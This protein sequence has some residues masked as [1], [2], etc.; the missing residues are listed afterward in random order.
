MLPSKAK[1]VKFPVFRFPLSVRLITN[2]MI[3][4]VCGRPGQ[5]WRLGFPLRRLAARGRLGQAGIGLY[6]F[7]LVGGEPSQGWR[8]GIPLRR[9]AAPDRLG[10]ADIGLYS[11]GLVCGEP[12]QGWR[13]GATN[14]RRG[15]W[16]SAHR[17]VRALRDSESAG[18]SQPCEGDPLAKAEC[19]GSPRTG[20]HRPPRQWMRMRQAFARLASRRDQPSQGIVDISPSVCEGA[21]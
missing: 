2:T 15:Q 6:S 12:A 14:P 16:T 19:A 10:Q 1:T 17:S 21:A 8:L 20:R 18:C 9:L 3:G 11:F 13:L 4:C 7:G 5:G